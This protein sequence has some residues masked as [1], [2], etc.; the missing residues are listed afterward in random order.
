MCSCVSLAAVVGL[1]LTFSGLTSAVTPPNQEELDFKAISYPVRIT[2]DNFKRELARYI[3]VVLV[4][5]QPGSLSAELIEVAHNNE[6]LVRIGIV[7]IFDDDVLE[8]LVGFVNFVLREL[9][10][11][12]SSAAQSLELAFVALPRTLSFVVPC[13]K[14]PRI[15]RRFG[16]GVQEQAG[17]T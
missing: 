11:G 10:A 7:D 6:A 13:S 12:P 5:Q 15:H 4:F 8:L 2:K 17:C 9:A 16:V 1:L 3:P 14:S